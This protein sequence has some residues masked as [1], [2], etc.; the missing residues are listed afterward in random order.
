MALCRCI[1]HQPKN[2]RGNFYNHAVNPVGYPNTSSICGRTQCDNP[3]LIYLTDNEYASFLAG[4]NI[5]QYSHNSSK[6][7]VEIP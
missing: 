5:F 2:N 7:K 6:V 3:G 4:H 1:N